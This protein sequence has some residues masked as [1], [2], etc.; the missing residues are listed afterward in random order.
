MPAYCGRHSATKAIVSFPART[1]SGSATSSGA[2]RRHLSRCASALTAVTLAT[3]PAAPPP[4]P[5][6]TATSR[7]L[8]KS[9]S[10]LFGRRSPGSL[11]EAHA[12]LSPVKARTVAARRS[13]PGR[14]LA[15]EVADL[16]GTAEVRAQP[17][18]PRQ[19]LADPDL[20]G[21]GI[22]DDVGPPVAGDGQER[23]RLVAAVDELV[24]AL[25][26]EPQ[27]QRLA[28]LELALALRRA[29]GGPPAYPIRARRERKP[30]GRSPF[31]NSGR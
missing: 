21:V 8:A 22:D 28:L 3:S 16:V 19:P 24:R 23:H 9:A 14:R 4:T 20:A 27:A 15:V 30:S 11:R 31:S 29:Q 25:L 18:T 17:A 2:S 6:A 10:S 5:S 13:P 7:G 26:A 12:R 1:A